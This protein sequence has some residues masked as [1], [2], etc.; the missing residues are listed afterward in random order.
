[1]KSHLIYSKKKQTNKNGIR[2]TN[3]A[4][5]M[6]TIIDSKLR[7]YSLMLAFITAST[8][9]SPAAPRH[10][11]SSYTFSVYRERKKMQ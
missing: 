4:L 7:Q 6:R 3:P 5:L 11:P 2:P 10:P 1:M 8:T 9:D